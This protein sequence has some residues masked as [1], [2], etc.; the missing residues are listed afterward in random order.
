MSFTK[1]DWEEVRKKIHAPV[2]RGSAH[3]QM[4]LQMVVQAGLAAE[5]VTGSPV[6]DRLLSIIQR[7]IE[8]AE[9]QRTA[10]LVQFESPDL[11]DPVELQRL[12]INVVICA[13]RIKA[14]KAI[15][16][17]PRE[18]MEN[19]AKAIDLVEQMDVA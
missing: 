15:I 16:S 7:G 9:R 3:S 19:A 6:W 2:S 13:E 10:Y 18:L 8:E 11:V 14:W 4:D 17:L 5:S 12:K 1:D